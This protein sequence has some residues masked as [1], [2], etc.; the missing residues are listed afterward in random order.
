[1]NDGLLGLFVVLEWQNEMMECTFTFSLVQRRYLG[2]S[3]TPAL[4][5]QVK[6]R[7]RTVSRS[8]PK[9]SSVDSLNPC[10]SVQH[11]RA[12]DVCIVCTCPRATQN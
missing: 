3:V 11:C 12:E 4:C 10:T 2:K 6:N 7:Q 8:I 9:A 5:G 1:M